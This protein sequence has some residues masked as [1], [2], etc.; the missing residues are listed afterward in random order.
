VAVAGCRWA[1]GV[2]P[3]VPRSALALATTMGQRPLHHSNHP[4]PDR[5]CP[6]L[7]A[8]P[9]YPSW[10]EHVVGGVC[11][12]PRS[13]RMGQRGYVRASGGLHPPSHPGPIGVQGI[14]K[15]R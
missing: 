5:G 9:L 2:Y 15:L 10:T 14:V 8:P 12:Y 4:H 3:Q 6:A 1:W 13:P 7:H 11:A